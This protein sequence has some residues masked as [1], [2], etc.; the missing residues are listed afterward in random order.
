MSFREL[1]LAYRLNRHGGRA[2]GNHCQI[3]ASPLQA[4]GGG[5]PRLRDRPPG[6]RSAARRQHEARVCDDVYVLN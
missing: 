5:P 3:R 4:S 1:V 6:S 2:T